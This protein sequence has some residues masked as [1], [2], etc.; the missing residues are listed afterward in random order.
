MKYQHDSFMV[1]PLLTVHCRLEDVKKW[2][3]AS[4]SVDGR[5]SAQHFMQAVRSFLG[6]CWGFLCY[7]V[8]QGHE[9]L[10]EL[11]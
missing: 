6:S 8:Q 4:Q 5:I 11:V 2:L 7:R 1:N 3:S 10:L 9:Q